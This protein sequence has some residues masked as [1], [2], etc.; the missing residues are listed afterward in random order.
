MMTNK[1]VLSALTMVAVSLG[2][3]TAQSARMPGSSGHQ[4]PD[5]DCVPG[6]CSASG[7]ADMPCF[8][9]G[10][11]LM[12]NM[13][14]ASVSFPRRLLVIPIPVENTATQLHTFSGRIRGNGIALT[15]CQA[16][17]I[18]S[19]NGA[20]GSTVGETTSSSLTNVT[21]GS[22]NVGSSSLVQVECQVAAM[23]EDNSLG[24]GVLRVN[25]NPQ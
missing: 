13:C 22:A 15:S 24:G 6:F 7:D 10:N 4:W 1:Y 2:V 17:V 8:D 21:M 20:V 16:L 19:N 5:P 23:R 11:G 9:H 3:G 12:Q 25:A 18:D 14:Q